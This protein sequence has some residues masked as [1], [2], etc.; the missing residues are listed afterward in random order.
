MGMGSAEVI[1]VVVGLL[2]WLI[3]LIIFLMVLYR[4]V[5]AAVRRELEDFRASSTPG[6]PTPE[7]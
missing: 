3:G 1:G 2:G 4:V 7:P 6:A 5:R